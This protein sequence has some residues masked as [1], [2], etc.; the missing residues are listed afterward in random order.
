MTV[1]LPL[2]TLGKFGLFESVWS[3]RG[4]S[5]RIRSGPFKSNG[6]FVYSS[7]LKNPFDQSFFVIH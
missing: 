4:K 5:F 1:M 6:R 2:G 3:Q 7:D